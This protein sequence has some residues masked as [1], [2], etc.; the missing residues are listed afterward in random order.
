MKIFW[1]ILFIIFL[2][3]GG[4]WIVLSGMHKN[5]KVFE[6]V[7]DDSGSWSIILGTTERDF[8]EDV[9]G[10]IKSLVYREATEHNPGGD[11]L[12]DGLD[13]GISK[14]IRNRIN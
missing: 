8:L 9:A 6:F 3:L 11:V 4:M 12:P 5:E 10:K 7:K 14:E 2:F 13:D 1:T